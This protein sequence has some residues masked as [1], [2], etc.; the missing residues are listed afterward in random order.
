MDTSTIGSPE[1]LL[2]IFQGYPKQLVAV[3]T[4]DRVVWLLAREVMGVLQLQNSLF[5]PFSQALRRARGG[6]R[7]RT[8]SSNRYSNRREPW[9]GAGSGDYC[10]S[11]RRDVFCQVK[12][13]G[14][15]P[16]IRILSLAA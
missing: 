7:P 11:A 12:R 14:R 5:E 3:K 8:R 2:N 1:K 16:W 4:V 13:R 9:L 15:D 10:R 6:C